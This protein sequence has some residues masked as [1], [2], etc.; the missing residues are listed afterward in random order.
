VFAGVL[1]CSAVLL[2]TVLLLLLL[3][4][5]AGCTASK[6]MHTATE[7]SQPR[8][9]L[10]CLLAQAHGGDTAVLP[11]LP[12]TAGLL[13]LQPVLAATAACAVATPKHT[14][15]E[16]CDPLVCLRMPAGT[17]AAAADVS[18]G[19]CWAFVLGGSGG[20]CSSSLQ[21]EGGAL[22]RM[23]LPWG[24]RYSCAVQMGRQ[25]GVSSSTGLRFL[26]AAWL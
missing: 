13:L 6:P 19:P 10:A 26:Q 18:H 16:A 25:Y 20:S 9:L 4:A 2:P 8:D 12:P 5:A 24:L 11:A 23:R 22:L 7:L 15:T 1:V 14:A 17:A 21:V 3:A